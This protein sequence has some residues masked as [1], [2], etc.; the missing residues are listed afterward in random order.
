MH[1][2]YVRPILILSSVR[3][4]LGRFNGILSEFHATDLGAIAIKAA[5][6]RAG[7]KPEEIQF[8][9]MG[10]AVGAGLGM[11]PAKAAA[12]KGGLKDSV[13]ARRVDSVCASSL[14]AIAI[15]C[16]AISSGAYDVAIAGG[17]E[18][19]TNAPYLVGPRME[20]KTKSYQ[21]G[22]RVKVKR[23][24]AY[25]FMFSENEVEQLHG[26]GLVDATAY[27]GLF[28]L[29]ERKFMRQYAIEFAREMGYSVELVNEYAARSHQ[30]ARMASSKGWFDDEIVACGDALKD[31]LPNDEQLSQML[32]EAKED[33]A[34][35]YNT[36]APV[37][38]AAA[39]VLASER[40]V[41]RLSAKPI[42]RV[43]GYSR[44]DCH[45]SK[46]LTAP[47]SAAVKLIEALRASGFSGKFTIVEANEAFA[48]QL[49]YFER[50]FEGMD[51][52]VHGG[53]VA[54]GHPLGAAGAR[55]LCTLLHAMKRY[56]HKY[57]LVTLC[58]GGGGGIA[59]AVE[60]L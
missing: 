51:M 17:M 27:D 13:C 1:Q 18:S 2:V 58:F 5:W 12:V 11:A 3:T 30:R 23:A 49:P 8:V 48:I 20:R 16:D 46:F 6:E 24:G 44:V 32:E 4:P 34:S 55:L 9:T 42:G 21:K 56:G 54:L 59:L 7:I 53:A 14:D 60:A 52:N 40:A 38:G 31:E 50:A 19:R 26:T 35:A 45:P 36:A 25:T 37:D 57:G 41:E 10:N 43:L 28:W 29:P 47:V 22:E 39:C 33:I 15:T